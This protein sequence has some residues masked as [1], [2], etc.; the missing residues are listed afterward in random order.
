MYYAD[1]AYKIIK[2]KFNPISVWEI[3]FQWLIGL[4]CKTLQRFTVK[5]Y[6]HMHDMKLRQ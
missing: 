3:N 2:M 1:Y 4:L 6:M 5:T